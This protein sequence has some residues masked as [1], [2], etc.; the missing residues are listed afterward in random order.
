MFQLTRRIQPCHGDDGDYITLVGFLLESARIICPGYD[1]PETWVELGEQ[2]QPDG[3]RV[4]RTTLG[5]HRTGM[6][7]TVSM[8]HEAG[9]ETPVEDQVG[10]VAHG[11]PPG[12]VLEIRMSRQR[13]GPRCVELTVSGA[14]EDVQSV[15]D[16]F[17][18]FFSDRDA[19]QESRLAYLLRSTAVSAR[20]H[21]WRTTESKALRCLEID[22]HNP[23]A[24]MYL[25]IA[26]AEQGFDAE[27]EGLLLASLMLDPKNVR[28]YYHSAMVA[29]RQGRCLTAA[30][31][32]SHA[33]SLN[34]QDHLVLYHLGKALEGMGRLKDALNAYMEALN[35]SPPAQWDAGFDTVDFRSLASASVDRLRAAADGEARAANACTDGP[36]GDQ[37]FSVG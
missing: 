31:F 12:I 28:A 29:L 26:R 22:P 34:P 37:V 19:S 4:S 20:L 27:G 32:L 25:G 30:D 18:K 5:D 23:E 36:L 11:L 33:R 10:V 14:E 7:V 35:A 15:L 8:R 2:T 24:T 6:T 16:R 13:E 9:S 1:P 17:E 21:A 3:T